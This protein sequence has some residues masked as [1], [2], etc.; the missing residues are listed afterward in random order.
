MK[1]PNC[2]KD[3]TWLRNY[4]KAEKVYAFNGISYD[5]I[6]EIIMTDEPEEFQCPQCDETLATKED[7][8]VKF[9]S[10]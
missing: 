1:C 6:D 10:A 2:N 7:E 9:L 8:A 4:T 5:E 3:I